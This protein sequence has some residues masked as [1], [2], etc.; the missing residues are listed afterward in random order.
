MKNL[1]KIMLA[2]AFLLIYAKGNAQ[3]YLIGSDGN[4]DT[5]TA[6]AS[7]TQET[8]GVYKGTI[9][10]T[11]R[12]FTVVTKLTTNPDDWQE[13]MKYRYCGP[14]EYDYLPP[15]F[16]DVTIQKMTDTTNG[17]SFVVPN[18]GTYE[19]TVDFNN[20]TIRIDR[21]GV[22]DMPTECHLLSAERGF[23]A[24]LTPQSRGL[25]KGNVDLG[26][27][28]T[29]YVT[30]ALITGSLA[31]G[32]YD[33][34]FVPGEMTN[35]E[36]KTAN[37]YK[38]ILGVHSDGSGFYVEVEGQ[39]EITVDFNAMIIHAKSLF[40]DNNGWRSE[41]YV[42]GNDDV[43]DCS[44]P[45]TTLPLIADGIYEG[46]GSFTGNW[47][48]IF[49]KLDGRWW[50]E[51]RYGPETDATP[52]SIDTPT[53]MYNNVEASWQITK[54]DY[55]VKVDFTKYPSTITVSNFA[56][57][58]DSVFADSKQSDTRIYN[59]SG[60]QLSKPQ[61]GINIIGGQKVVVK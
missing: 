15:A 5:T 50:S 36:N 41:I 54:G 38:A 30:S 59:L 60:Q 9:D 48:T 39:Y 2:T 18:E 53:N 7:L 47:F 21:E 14:A 57:G 27:H 29:F 58:I 19:L 45:R 10:F 43:W 1:L 42:V 17:A 52:I 32:I 13:L 56:T 37:M 16:Q 51:Y 33:Y 23:L 25:F 34:G 12:T 31:D 35:I 49:K 11:A 40:D 55:Y 4:W 8:T 6:S 3:C 24:D 61:K 28:E 26:S 46:E 20:M 22:T 44:N